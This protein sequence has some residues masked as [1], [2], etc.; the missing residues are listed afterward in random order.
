MKVRGECKGKYSEEA[1]A[2]LSRAELVLRVIRVRVTDLQSAGTKFSVFLLRSPAHVPS[3]HLGF[4]IGLCTLR[5]S[6]VSLPRGTNVLL[7]SNHMYFK[8]RS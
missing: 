5:Y 1:A 3:G 7:S 6:L 4:E 2:G 8:G